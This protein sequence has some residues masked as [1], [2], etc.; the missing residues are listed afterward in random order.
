M[1]K[2][3][4]LQIP[5]LSEQMAGEFYFNYIEFFICGFAML[6]FGVVCFFLNNQVFKSVCF[7]CYLEGYCFVRLPSGLCLSFCTFYC[8]KHFNKMLLGS[9][10]VHTDGYSGMGYS[11][12]ITYLQA[13]ES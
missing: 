9:I 5:H 2:R 8:M 3:V 6:W 1:R 12:E 4:L 10:R 7:E 13:P 11:N